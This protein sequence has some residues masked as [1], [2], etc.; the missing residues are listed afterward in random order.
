VQVPLQPDA[1][2]AMQRIEK[3]YKLLSEDKNS[4]RDGHRSNVFARWPAKSVSYS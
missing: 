4:N 3:V 1:I 2:A